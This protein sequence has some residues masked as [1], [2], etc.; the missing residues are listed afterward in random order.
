MDPD[1]KKCSECGG[2]MEKGAI[3]DYVRTNVLHPRWMP[4]AGFTRNWLGNVKPD[5]N[6]CRLVDTYRC[7]NCG[8]LKSYATAIGDKPVM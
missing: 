4:S 2:E 7:Q 8:Y 5:W 6:Q 3:L 1:A